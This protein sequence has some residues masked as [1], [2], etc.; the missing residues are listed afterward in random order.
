M[1]FKPKYPQEM[2]DWIKQNPQIKP[3]KMRGMIKDM[4]GYDV[5]KKS[6]YNLYAHHALG[7]PYKHGHTTLSWMLKPL[8]NERKDKDGYIRVRTETGEKLKH[9]IVW[10]QYHKPIA[11]DECIIFLDGDRTH[12]DIDNL[13]LMKRKYMGAVNDILRNVTITPEIKLAGIN[14][15]ILKLTARDKE[16]QLIKNDKR[17]APKTDGWR[18]IVALYNQG[19]TTNE[20]AS[21]TGKNKAVIRWTVRRYNNGFYENYIGGNA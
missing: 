6:I 18:L 19:K 2:F 16:I 3:S 1:V 7:K 17:H 21:E 20:I 9:H 4:F 12:C 10:E 5:P 13:Y 11:K 8:G 14:A 15:A